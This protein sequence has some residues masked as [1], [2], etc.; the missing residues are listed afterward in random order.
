MSNP[1]VR[2]NPP[3]RY[4]E[5]DIFQTEPETEPAKAAF[6]VFLGP[7]EHIVMSTN[8]QFPYKLATLSDARGDLSKRWRITFYVWDS[9][10]SNLVRKQVWISAKFKTKAQRTAEANRLIQGIN[11]LLVEG[12]HLTNE[13]PAKKQTSAKVL[14]WVEAFNWVYAHREPSLRQRSRETL[15]LIRTELIKWCTLRG[16]EHLPVHLVTQYHCDDFMQWIRAERRVGNA[17]YNNYL[18]FLKLNFNYLVDRD[19]I[20]KSPAFRLKPLKTEEAESV[21]FPPEVKKLLLDNYPEELK[22]LAQYIYYSFVRPGELRKL[23]VKHIHTHTIFVPGSISKNRK[24]QHVLIPPALERLLQ[25]LQVRSYPPSY[26]LIGLRGLPAAKPVSTNYF[27]S[28][29]LIVKRELQLPQEYTLYCWKHTGVTDTYRET[30]DIDF[31][32]RQC[33]HSS[34]DMTKRYLRGLGMLADYPQQDSLPDLG[35]YL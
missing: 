11:K 5:G 20:V 16:L 14:T 28:K 13:A 19:R 15:A 22:I 6:L 18:S 4:L 32:S 35:L 25:Q 3:S 2:T 23:R 26:Y 30:R 31:V 10:I 8:S 33:R 9:R 24:S 27:T 1:L 7:S 21:H 12:Y 29:H 17:T 34:L